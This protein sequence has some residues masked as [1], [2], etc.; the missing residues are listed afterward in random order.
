MSAEQLQLFA[1]L[2]FPGRS[3]LMLGEIA[4]RL[5]CSHR[6]LLN[7]IDDGSLVIIDLATSGRSRRTARV[8]IEAYR[9]FIV[10][11]LSGPMDA[12]MQFLKDLP[13]PV[14]AELFEE[15]KALLKA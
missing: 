14:L 12:R 3:T 2:D 13:R 6:H 4:D 1:S 5:G 9:T 8:P 15:I 7:K 11:H 10:K